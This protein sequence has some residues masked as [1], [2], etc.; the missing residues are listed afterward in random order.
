ML[1]AQVIK[2]LLTLH[3]A[4]TSAICGTRN[5]EE[6]EGNIVS[7]PQSVLPGSINHTKIQP[8]CTGIPPGPLTTG[9]AAYY[10]DDCQTWQLCRLL[11]ASS[12][13]FLLLLK[14]PLATQL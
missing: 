7:A 9:W 11:K 8:P 13:H 5:T 6:V 14:A 12:G 4:D 3:L 1:I 2:E 10:L